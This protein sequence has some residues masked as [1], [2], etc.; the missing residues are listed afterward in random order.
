MLAQEASGTAE[1]LRLA[2]EAKAA[3]EQNDAAG[4]VA[5]MEAA[6]A[7][8]PDYP[9]FLVDLAAAQVAAERFDDAVGTLERL[10]ALGVHASIDQAEE[11]TAVRGRKEFQAV[12]K[13]LAANLE[14]KGAAEIAFT[15][16]DVTGLIE[17]IAWRE[18]TGEFYFG[19]VNGRAVWVRGKDGALRR[20]TPDAPELLGVFGLAID[21]E[22]GALWAATSAVPAMQGFAPEQEGSAALV[23]LD[24][25]SG[26]IRGTFPAQ[27]SGDERHVLRD[28]ALA[29]DGT[30][31]VIDRASPIVWRLAAGGRALEPFLRSLE[32]F[33]LQAIA[34][35]PDGAALI[36][37][38]INGVVHADLDRR[39]VQRVA[40]PE[41]VTLIGIHG[42]TARPDGAVLALQSGLRPVRV[43]AL[44]VDDTTVTRVRVLESGHLAMAAP[45]LGCIGPGGDFY[46]IGN[47]G[48][49]RFFN[50]DGK[51]TAPRAV[52]IFRTK[53]PKR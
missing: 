2:R 35:R 49:N 6:V 16:R 48:W 19:D 42:L 47:P 38:E 18:K 43:V 24:L 23:E 36:A 17:G 27:S 29:P 3:A 26:E 52:A 28:V 11:F 50:D 9:R 1:A 44:E 45:S 8:R 37:D 20:L 15:L 40:V 46:Y 33:A 10:A 41:N 34:I 53:L 7:L 39:S 30:V 31:Y 22:R 13:K 32:F 4:Y 25:S 51:P 14:S 12:I 5:K 21:E